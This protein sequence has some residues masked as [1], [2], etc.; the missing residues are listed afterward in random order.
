MIEHGR[1]P[2][3]KKAA[4]VVSRPFRHIQCSP[5]ATLRV[6]GVAK[7][8]AIISRM[9]LSSIRAEKVRIPWRDGADT[10]NQRILA[11]PTWR[12]TNHPT[13]SPADMIR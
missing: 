12:P 5:S 13:T 4:P 2:R 8:A 11:R 6:A 7:V 10:F 9:V 3:S 1:T